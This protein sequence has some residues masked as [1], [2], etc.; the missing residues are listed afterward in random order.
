MKKAIFRI[1]LIG[2]PIFLAVLVAFLSMGKYHQIEVLREELNELRESDL[3]Q[4]SKR[5]VERMREEQRQQ[6]RQLLG[7]FRARAHDYDHPT[8]TGQVAKAAQEFGIELE[9]VGVEE[10]LNRDGWSFLVLEILGEGSF[11]AL[12]SL[13]R[14]LEENDQRFVA[15]R[16]LSV[17]GTER[18]GILQFECE[19]AF[20]VGVPW[21]AEDLAPTEEQEMESPARESVPEEPADAER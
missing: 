20:L 2:Y 14:D 18:P 12:M 7:Q 17:D 5:E 9:M 3:F 16:E 4:E 6:I 8:L 19:A 11:P 21:T 10:T 1:L 15:T 13:L